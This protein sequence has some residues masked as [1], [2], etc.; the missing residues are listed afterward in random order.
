MNNSKKRQLSRFAGLVA[1]LIVGRMSFAGEA[2]SAG[3]ITVNSLSLNYAGPASEFTSG[4][5]D[6]THNSGPGAHHSDGYGPFQSGSSSFMYAGTDALADG[7]STA[8]YEF[9]S[10]ATYQ[11][12][13]TSG[14]TMT[15][16][17]RYDV[18]LAAFAS[19]TTHAN[20]SAFNGEHVFY[21]DSASNLKSELGFISADTLIGNLGAGNVS[22][23]G[24]LIY[25]VGAY[26]SLT[27]EFEAASTAFAQASETPEPTSIAGLALGL[28][29]FAFKRRSK[30]S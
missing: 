27:I 1:V 12:Y 15:A 13:N 6:M 4:F 7:N 17:L 8:G 23:T 25:S 26:S 18:S 29:F 2:R 24:D 22:Y 21:W 10:Y 16:D 11:L 20:L 5:A 14:S 19:V 28:G 9:D 30:K 3:S